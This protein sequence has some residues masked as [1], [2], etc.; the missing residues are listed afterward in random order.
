MICM[1]F[2][3]AEAKIIGYAE[4]PYYG[5]T[6][7]DGGYAVDASGNMRVVGKTYD[8][9]ECGYRVCEIKLN[10]KYG[11]I[12]PK[13][14]VITQ[15]IWD[16]IGGV[17]GWN[18]EDN[19]CN[20]EY[21]DAEING[22]FGI[23]DFR[24]KIIS[25]FIWDKIIGKC[26]SKTDRALEVVINDAHGI[27]GDDGKIMI[28]PM[29]EKIFKEKFESFYD[30]CLFGNYDNSREA[31]LKYLKPEDKVNKKEDPFNEYGLAISTSDNGWKK[32]VYSQEKT[33]LENKYDY[34]DI[35]LDGYIKVEL[36]NKFAL[37]DKDGKEVLPLKYDKIYVST[38]ANVII[39][40][41]NKK[42]A[43]FNKYGKE[44]LPLK[45]DDINIFKSINGYF[46]RASL[47]GKTALLDTN[48][49]EIISPE[50]D[51]ILDFDDNINIG[52][53]KNKD[54]CGY[55]D[56]NQQELTKI[57]FDK[58]LPFYIEEKNKIAPA[59]KV[60][61]YILYKKHE[62]YFLILEYDKVIEKSYEIPFDAKV[63]GGFWNKIS[64]KHNGK[65][66]NTIYFTD[67]EII[68]I[69]PDRAKYVGRSGRL[70]LKEDE[71]YHLYKGYDGKEFLFLANDF[72]YGSESDL[73]A[74]Q[75]GNGL[76]DIGG[77][78]DKYWVYG[79]EEDLSR[80]SINGKERNIYDEASGFDSKISL[81]DKSEEFAIAYVKKGGKAYIINE[82]ENIQ[83]FSYYFEVKD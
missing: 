3:L 69:E 51:D 26:F 50:Y 83:P 11:L 75:K 7:K 47:N 22:K 27:I 9:I 44:I 43:L 45:Y 63:L 28:E 65:E 6:Y 25:P 1:L 36:D 56:R 72:K 19:T 53:V 12:S 62:I 46:I 40:I 17:C 24:G 5:L 59:E 4:L 64:W 41:L 29:P 54:K 77:K 10:G 15:P 23:V 71:Y 61:N 80:C 33:I 66:F 21:F 2:S 35:D 42:A 18:D 81:G 14:F 30:F 73:I 31:L 8:S 16:S 79:R 13:G 55:I 52:I 70:A 38:K 82:D 58:C 57:K 68:T 39:A 20:G 34:V 76:C 49:N 37:F 60:T 48:G 78:S 74:V 67:G 32:G